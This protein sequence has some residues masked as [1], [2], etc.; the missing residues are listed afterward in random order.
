MKSPRKKVVDSLHDS[1]NVAFHSGIQLDETLPM[2]L[3]LC[4]DVNAFHFQNRKNSQLLA[5]AIPP[6]I[7]TAA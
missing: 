1:N 7:N 3:V 4:Q 2:P 5:P 6:D